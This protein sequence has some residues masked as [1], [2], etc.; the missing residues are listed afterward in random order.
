MHCLAIQHEAG[1]R[2]THP[3]LPSVYATQVLVAI[4]HASAINDNSGSHVLS[5][6]RQLHPA[7]RT[8]HNYNTAMCKESCPMNEVTIV[9]DCACSLS[10]TNILLVL[11]G[12]CF[13]EF[14]PQMNLWYVRT[15]T[16]FMSVDNS[17]CRP[18]PSNQNFY[19]LIA[20]YQRGAGDHRVGHWWEGSWAYKLVVVP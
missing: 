5:W 4:V 7:N 13:T 19:R 16:M 1:C 20:G 3:S 9:L 8:R 15:T 6:N 18:S 2:A 11:Q 10:S 12:E 14:Q 17:I